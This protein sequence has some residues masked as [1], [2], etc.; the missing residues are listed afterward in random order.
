VHSKAEI[1]STP[2]DGKREVVDKTIVSSK[3]FGFMVSSFSPSG[4]SSK[5]EVYYYLK[6]RKQKFFF[7]VGAV[8]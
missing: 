4:A 6:K 3:Y 8:V 7:V 2:A 1:T 5:G